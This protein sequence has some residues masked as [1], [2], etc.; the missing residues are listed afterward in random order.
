MARNSACGIAV[1]RF[2]KGTPVRAVWCQFYNDKRQEWT[3]RRLILA[4]EVD[5]EAQTIV[6]LYARRWG[7]E[8][9]FHNLKRWW[10]FNNLWQQIR[11]C[12]WTLTQSLSLAIAEDFPMH[13]IAPLRIGQPVTAGLVAQWLHRE[14]T[15]LASHTPV[16]RKSRKLQRRRGASRPL[17]YQSMP[18]LRPRMRASSQSQSRSPFYRQRDG[19]SV[20]VS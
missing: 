1:A 6:Q 4:S 18:L 15:G 10:G 13:E 5:L 9:L 3:K 12:T 7:I 16:Q 19:N 8:P 14:F 20:R 2:L 11:S 17:S